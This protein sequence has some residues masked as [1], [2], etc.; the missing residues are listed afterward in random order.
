MQRAPGICM[1][2]CVEL[3]AGRT[4]RLYNVDFII[5]VMQSNIP[6]NLDKGV[7]V[8]NTWCVIGCFLF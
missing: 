7:R 8:K 5:G 3:R 2:R 1:A 4:L 6:I